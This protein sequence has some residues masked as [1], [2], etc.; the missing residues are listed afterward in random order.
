M[1]LHGPYYFLLDAK[2][3]SLSRQ[4]I[5]LFEI[6]NAVCILWINDLTDLTTMLRISF[7]WTGHW[8]WESLNVEIMLV[9]KIQL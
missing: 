4:N 6:C 9:V 7:S 3:Y 1:S 2:S 5:V 8:P